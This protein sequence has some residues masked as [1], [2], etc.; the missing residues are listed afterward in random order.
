L[1][2]KSLDNVTVVIITFENFEKAFMGDD[3]KLSAYQ[4]T[5][6]DKNESIEFSNPKNL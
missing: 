3:P 6:Q 4:T 1:F 5:L 2:R